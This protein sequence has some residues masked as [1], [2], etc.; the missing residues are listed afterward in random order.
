MLE[1]KYSGKDEFFWRK[2]ILPEED[3]VSFIGAE[4]KGGYRWFRGENII[5]FEHY[6]VVEDKPTPR[7]KAS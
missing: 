6:R 5:C 7:L 1:K 2:L 3:H 4:W